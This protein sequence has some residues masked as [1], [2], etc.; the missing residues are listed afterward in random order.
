MKNERLRVGLIGEHLAHSFSPRIHR[1][2]A[3]YDYRLI[4]LARL[5][6]RVALCILLPSFVI[7]FFLYNTPYRKDV[8]VVL[9]AVEYN[10]ETGETVAS[11]E[12][13]MRGEMKYFLFK[14]INCISFIKG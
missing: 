2:L 13:T 3:D 8:N 14:A 12:V 11:R 4:E 9:P 7:A 1:E 6:G 10:V 5:F